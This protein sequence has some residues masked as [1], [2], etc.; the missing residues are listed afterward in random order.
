MA[1]SNRAR[2]GECA[3]LRAE[4][5]S[6][7]RGSVPAPACERARGSGPPRVVCARPA[8]RAAAGGCVC[9][10]GGSVGRPPA[11]VGAG[12]VRCAGVVHSKS[13]N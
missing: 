2:P 7:R 11:G 6:A 9:A 3:R 4:Q 10:R 13:F 12:F 5:G 1:R 8:V